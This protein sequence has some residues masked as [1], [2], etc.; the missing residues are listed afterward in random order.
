MEPLEQLFVVFM[1]DILVGPAFRILKCH[2]KTFIW[3]IHLK[4]IFL[5]CG[6]VLERIIFLIDMKAVVYLKE[7]GGKGD[8]GQLRLLHIMY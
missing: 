6:L 5:G 8:M 4:A 3:N 2:L 1:Q 7:N